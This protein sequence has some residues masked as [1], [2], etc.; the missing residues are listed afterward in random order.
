MIRPRRSLLFMPGSNPR[1]L[2]KAKHLHADGLILDLEDSVAPDAKAVARSQIAAAVSARG[3]GAR[4]V[5]IRINALDSPWWIEDL[6]MAAK[7]RP[8]GILVPKVSSVADLA[9][10]ADRLSDI[11]A[12]ISIRVWAMLE[13]ARSVLHADALAA[14]S[15]D[16]EMRLAGFVFGPNDLSLETGIRMLP[17]RAAMIGPIVHC[18]LAARAHG[19]AILDGPYSDIGNIEGFAHECAQ[20]RDLGFDGK[21]LIHPG[22]SLCMLGRCCS[23]WIPCWLMIAWA[24]RC[25]PSSAPCISTSPWSRQALSACSLCCE[26]LCTGAGSSRPGLPPRLASNAVPDRGNWADADPVPDL[27]PATP[28]RPLPLHAGGALLTAGWRPPT[29]IGHRAQFHDSYRCARCSPRFG[30]MQP[31]PACDRLWGD[32]APDTFRIADIHVAGGSL[33]HPPR[34]CNRRSGTP[35]LRSL[36]LPGLVYNRCGGTR[37]D[38]SP[39]RLADSRAK[40]GDVQAAVVSVAEMQAPCPRP[41]V[42]FWI[43][44]DGRVAPRQ[45]S[46]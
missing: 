3:F 25:P 9:A 14:A 27:S 4:E 42:C 31:Q 30:H 1:A 37:N 29:T 28:P 5:L 36:L 23:R 16:S 38:G 8:D 32:G 19:L 41:G 22:H 39:T 11:N 35:S 10:I 12:D 13:T 24:H 43:Y 44:A 21:T 33:A 18:I 17:G 6:A 20:A 45:S 26:G 7:A 2:E 40:P 34:Q 15:S 46:E